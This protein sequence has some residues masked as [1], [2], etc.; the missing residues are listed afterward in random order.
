MHRHR[1]SHK[2][3]KSEPDARDLIYTPTALP[4]QPSG[5]E[6]PPKEDDA[7]AVA[8]TATSVAPVPLF[9]ARSRWIA[10]RQNKHDVPHVPIVFDLRTT[11]PSIPPILDQ[12]NLGA[13][14]AN[15]LSSALR[16]CLA[17]QALPDFQPS[18]LFIYYFARLLDGSPLSEDSG[19][20]IR[21]GLKAIQHFGAPPEALWPYDIAR[22]FVHPSKDA[23][24]KAKARGVQSFRYLSVAQDIFHIRHALLAGFPILLGIQVYA[25]MESAETLATG[26]VPMPHVLREACY[27]GH[28][29][30]LWGWDDAAKSFLMMNSWGSKVGKDGWFT[31]PY[32]YI[33]HPDLTFDMWTIRCW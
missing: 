21:S 33:L 15:E 27:G 11:S 10:A 32:D 18:R 31:I 5:G 24:S 20:T 26:A 28:C 2:L 1:R 3:I 25:S 22:F 17:K 12:G 13:C 29:V 14:G 19:I 9:G 30:S 7:V 4:P 16:Y 23:F 8:A 6:A